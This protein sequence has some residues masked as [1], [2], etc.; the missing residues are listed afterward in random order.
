MSVERRGL[1]T[2]ITFLPSHPII[3]QMPVALAAHIDPES[4]DT[5]RTATL[6]PCIAAAPAPPCH[7][8]GSKGA[9][10]SSRPMRPLRCQCGIRAP[11]CRRVQNR[12]ASSGS[13]CDRGAARI[14]RL[15]SAEQSRAARLHVCCPP[16][17]PLRLWIQASSGMERSS[18]AAAGSSSFLW[19]G[20]SLRCPSSAPAPALALPPDRDR[21]LRAIGCAHRSSNETRRGGATF[22]AQIVSWCPP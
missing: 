14:L 18:V 4:E 11:R 6:R 16:S 10:S 19:P 3:K 1:N 15:F 21:R 17:S 7:A 5:T 20:W 13:S 2:F 8:S 12:S 22:W 9:T